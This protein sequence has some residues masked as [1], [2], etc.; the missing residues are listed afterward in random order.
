MA[1]KLSAGAM[2]ER[3]QLL[4]EL[5]HG[6]KEQRELKEGVALRFEASSDAITNLGRLI[7]LERECCPFLR[8][9]LLIEAGD[10]PLWLE[11][12]AQPAAQGLVR[13]LFPAT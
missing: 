3:K 5:T 6:V 13:E 11:I 4:A 8:F 2:T 7:A 1:C 12:T 9:R 10:G